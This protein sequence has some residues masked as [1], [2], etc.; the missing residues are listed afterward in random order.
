ML[1]PLPAIDLGQASPW[2]ADWRLAALKRNPDL[3]RRVLVTPHIEAQ[4]IADSPLRD[5]CGWVNGVRMSAAGGVRAGFDKITC[6]AATALALWLEH[7]LQEVAKEILGQRVTA[8]QSFGTYSC[9]NIIG[10]PLWKS[11]RASMPPPMP[12]ISAASRWPTGG[13]SPCAGIG[14]A[15]G[16]KRASCGPRTAA[17]AA[18]SG[19]CLGPSTTPPTTTISTST[20]ARCRGAS[21]GEAS[22]ISHLRR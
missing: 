15:T 2:L 19:W 8:V 20:A 7:D 10:N 17:L 6:E 11:W 9:R 22:P 14:A 3:C 16:R 1:D 18:I 5:G 12:S 4:P 13:K 21:D